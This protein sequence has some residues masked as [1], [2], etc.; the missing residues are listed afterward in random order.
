MLIVVAA[1][2]VDTAQAHVGVG[3]GWVKLDRLFE[4]TDGL[5]NLTREM[6]ESAQRE[7]GLSIVGITFQDGKLFGDGGLHIVVQRGLDNFRSPEVVGHVDRWQ[8][9]AHS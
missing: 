8:R 3:I 6:A 7:I 5:L 9:T 4:I 1:D 2:G